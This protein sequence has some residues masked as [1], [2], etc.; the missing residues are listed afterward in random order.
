[1]DCGRA[2]P[3]PTT[4]ALQADGDLE[5]DH[6]LAEKLGMSVARMR[7][8]IS[9]AEYVRWQVYYGRQVQRRE[10]AAKKRF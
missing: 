6:F 2:R 8:E 7:E 3:R 9:G 1:M 4:K 10:I 5:F